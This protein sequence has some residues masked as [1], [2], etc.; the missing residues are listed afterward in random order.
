M[1]KQASIYVPWGTH[2][3]TNSCY[4]Y[5]FYKQ[6]CNEHLRICLCEP[7]GE[8]L[9]GQHWKVGSWMQRC[10]HWKF[11]RCW[12]IAF[13]RWPI[14]YPLTLS[15]W[16]FHVCLVSSDSLQSDQCEKTALCGLN[17]NFLDCQ[18]GLETL[19][20]H[21]CFLIYRLLVHISPHLFSY[22]AFTSLMCRELTPILDPSP[23]LT[24]I[25]SYRVS[26]L[27]LSP[28]V[29]SSLRIFTLF[30]ETTG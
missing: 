12:Q 25:I 30:W 17:F 7:M 19:S 20:G 10:T 6:H 3:S 24:S 11:I 8:F 15:M 21:S 26:W 22:S 1:N 23:Q 28:L 2:F 29:S 18:W 4:N 14:I 13:Q 9:W 27:P 5:S 16:V